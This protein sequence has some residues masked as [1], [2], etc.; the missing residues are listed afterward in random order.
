[1]ICG[2]NLYQ[3]ANAPCSGNL[4]SPLYCDEELTGLL[5]FGVNCGIAN[6]PPVFTQVRFFNRW[7]DQQIVNRVS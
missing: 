2:G 5:S 6:D 3:N 1:M 7:I 4:G